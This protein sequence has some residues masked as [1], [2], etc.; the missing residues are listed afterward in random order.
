[1]EPHNSILLEHFDHLIS[2]KILSREL[3]ILQ[4]FSGIQNLLQAER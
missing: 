4:I 3:V 2:E 1:M